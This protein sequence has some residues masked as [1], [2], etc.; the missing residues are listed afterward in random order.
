MILRRDRFVS[1]AGGPARHPVHAIV[2]HDCVANLP[3]SYD[4]IQRANFKDYGLATYSPSKALVGAV[5]QLAEEVAETVRLA[6]DWADDFALAEMPDDL[7][8]LPPMPRP[9]F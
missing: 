4:A 8:G 7:P 5:A 9:K 1:Q 6:P 2:V 3:G